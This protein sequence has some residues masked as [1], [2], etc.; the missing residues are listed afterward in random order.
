MNRRRAGA[1]VN[2]R[3]TGL[4]LAAFCLGC[5]LVGCG[6]PTGPPKAVPSGQ[7]PTGLLSPS[8]PPT[9]TTLPAGGVPFYVYLVDAQGQ[10]APYQREVA[11]HSGLSAILDYLFAGPSLQDLE[12]GVTT[13][14]PSGSQ[15][16]SVGPPSDN[17][18][19]VNFSADFGAPVSQHAQILAVAQVVY[20]IANAPSIASTIGVIFEIDGTPIAVPTGSGA[21][22]TQPVT[23]ANYPGLLAPTTTTTTT[24]PH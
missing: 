14:I 12:A 3:R 16:L 10:L 2:R 5:L 18:V 15:V 13:A 7:I 6:V 17:V 20:T 1:P 11:L 9:N 4:V 19:A 21:E 23:V 22:T 24:P 8:L